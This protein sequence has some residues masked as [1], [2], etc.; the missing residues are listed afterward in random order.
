MAS[1]KKRGALEGENGGAFNTSDSPT[2]AR[3]APRSL[4]GSGGHEIRE[5]TVP[6][7]TGLRI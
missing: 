7:F 3:Y 1:R 6:N 5:D 2:R 4:L